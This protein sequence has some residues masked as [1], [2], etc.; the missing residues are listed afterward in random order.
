M[1]RSLTAVL[2]CAALVAGCAN[3]TLEPPYHRP[4]APV[5]SAFPTGQA[6]APSPAQ[7]AA[8][9][10]WRE[11]FVDP[12]LRGVIEQALADSRDLRVAI[13][14]IEAAQAQYRVQRA[15]L[16]PTL[17]ATASADYARSYTGLPPSLGG[18]Y[19]RSTQYSASLG[20]TSYEL[21]LFGKVRSLTK[22]ALEQ[23]LATEAARRSTEITL[24]A[25]V[26][27][28][29]LTLAADE[30][31]L[32]VSRATVD[33]GAQNLDLAQR[34]LTGGVGSQLDVSNARTIVEQAR[35]D[36]GRY[37]T[38]VAQDRNALDL[39]VGA[40][41]AAD[42]LPGGIDDPGARLPQIPV[43]LDSALLLRRPDVVEVEHQ[44]RAA[45]A[46]IGA[47]R[48]AFF[49][50]IAL[51]GSGGSTTASLSS[52]FAG[53][54]GVW[55]FNPTISL[56]IFDGGAN[57]ANLAYARAQDRIEIADYEKAIQTAF[58]EVADALADHG[59]IAERLRAQQ[60]LV[61]AAADSLR[62]SQALYARGSDSYIDVLTAQ[63][64]L[65]G[66]QQS[67]IAIQLTAA[68]NI[69]TLYK[70]LGGGL[71]NETAVASAR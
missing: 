2:M 13:A 43:A 18:P 10:G 45:N 3:G 9:P 33:S 6:Y 22:A 11:V 48:A 44:L 1:I 59:T 50:S 25:Q 23:Y 27:G 58:R 64:T 55:A 28:D 49:P 31:L 40:P 60:A 19:A 35:A 30:S 16:L 57:R 41:V 38:Q 54:T 21:D 61:D 14:Q 20:V 29:W 39:V 56:P 15:A 71:A 67:R 24:V 5:P 53:G 51:T 17:D 34:R 68:N 63:R 66:A 70:V 8:A 36:V 46:D 12:R 62:L 42:A 52:L 37:I 32:S 69:V 47:A 7:T 26:A 65:Y 4:V